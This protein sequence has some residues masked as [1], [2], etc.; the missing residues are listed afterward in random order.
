MC[1]V[2]DLR[3]NNAGVLGGQALLNAV[4]QNSSSSLSSVE[5]LGNNI[6]QDTITAIS[7]LVTIKPHPINHTPSACPEALV[8]LRAEQ[9]TMDDRYHSQ[10]EMMTSKLIHLQHTAD[11]KVNTRSP[12]Y[13]S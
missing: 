11:T 5:L 13:S 2:T 4:E 6:P 8:Q 12:S 7:E 3:W 1:F 9:L 10:H